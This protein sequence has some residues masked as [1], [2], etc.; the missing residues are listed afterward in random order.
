MTSSSRHDYQASYDLVA[1]EYARRN[2]DELDR[3]PLDRK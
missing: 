1:D 3:K 2:F